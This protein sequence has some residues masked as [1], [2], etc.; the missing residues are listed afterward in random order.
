VEHEHLEF[1]IS[2]YADG[3]LDEADRAAVER[4]LESDAE[5]R[6]MLEEHRAVTRLVRAAPLPQVRWDRLAETISGAIEDEMSARM[7]RASW[8]IRPIRPM[9]IAM[10]AS[11]LIAAGIAVHF[12]MGPRN[13]ATH[14]TGG[15]TPAPRTLLVELSQPDRPQGRVVSDISI[16]AG[17]TYAKDSTL[18]PYADD[19]DT[20]PP[21]VVIASGAST[22]SP[23]NLPF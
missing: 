13:T 11:V 21:H 15:T 18:T 1:L 3:T 10:A 4:R 23:A 22:E 5:A 9:W 14:P 6:A 2:Q 20:R 7:R 17:G 8:A 12:V 19:I 16:G